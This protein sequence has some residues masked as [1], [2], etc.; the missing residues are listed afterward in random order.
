MDKGFLERAEITGPVSVEGYSQQIYIMRDDLIGFSF[1]GNKVRIAWE[2]LQDM[3]EKGGDCMIAYGSS[4]SNMCRALA[5]LCRQSGYPCYVLTPEED[6]VA[7]GTFN[8]HLVELLGAQIRVCRKSNVAEAVEILMAELASRGYHPYYMF[9][10]CFGKGNEEAAARAYKRV[11]RNILRY[12]K[13]SGI[14]FSHIFLASGT[15]M[16]QGGLVAGQQCY[17]G[18]KDIV[19]ISVAR[20][21]DRGRAEV[22]RFAGTD[23]EKV[24]FEDGYICGGYGR[25]DASVEAVIR[26]MME[27]HGIPLDP[28]YTGKAFTGMLKWMKRQ[29]ILTPVLFL[30]TGGLPLYFDYLNQGHR[31]AF[32]DREA[33]PS[34][35]GEKGRMG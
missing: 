6:M 33:C 4:R 24:H 18:N 2:L 8:S 19:G 16:T 7:E 34:L 9:G 13:D 23:E 21:R 5:N 31:A 12:E 3:E 29:E 15:G 27:I 10:D 20:P 32:T 1:G 25:Y 14:E 26:Y 11:Y 17:G 22:A 28:T 30:H 35:D